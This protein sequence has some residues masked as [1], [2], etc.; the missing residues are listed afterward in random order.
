MESVKIGGPGALAPQIL[1]PGGGRQHPVAGGHH[2]A[3]TTR[4]QNLTSK[5]FV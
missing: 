5:N 4:Y 3:P 1:Y 2:Q